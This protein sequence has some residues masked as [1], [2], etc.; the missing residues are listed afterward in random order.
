MLICQ[1]WVDGVDGHLLIRFTDVAM[2]NVLGQVSRRREFRE[3]VGRVRGIL[4]FSFSELAHWRDPSLSKAW[5]CIHGDKL[6]NQYN[7]A[8]S[9][10]F[11][12][13]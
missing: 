3:H 4:D 9:L 11:L 1:F 10:I 8:V 6:F 12:L 13:T 5:L 2:R 7:S